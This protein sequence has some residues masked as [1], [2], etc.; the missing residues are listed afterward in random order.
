MKKDIQPKYYQDA[1]V[2][3]ACGNKFKIG[4]TQKSIKVEICSLCH[5]FYSGAHKFIDKAGRVDK[6]KVKMDKFETMRADKIRKLHE[7]AKKKKEA[8]ELLRSRKK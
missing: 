2:V 5:P 6:F 7:K 3:C 8:E 4:S 1:E